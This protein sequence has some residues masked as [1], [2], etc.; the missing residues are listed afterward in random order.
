MLKMKEFLVAYDY[1]MGALW[2]V[3]VA[4]SEE[5]VEK[6][7]S[8]MK[9]FHDRPEWMNDKQY[10]EIISNSYWDISGGVRPEWV[11][12]YEEGMR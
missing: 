6:K 12:L 11:K 7:Y 1:G 8:E 2:G 10:S 3:V 4:S 5:E 9:I